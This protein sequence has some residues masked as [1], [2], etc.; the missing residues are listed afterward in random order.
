MAVEAW[1]CQS[2]KGGV[3]QVTT[4]TI[5]AYLISVSF[6]GATQEADLSEI[7]MRTLRFLG[8]LQWKG[9]KNCC[10][11]KLRWQDTNP[12]DL[13]HR[14]TEYEV[15]NVREMVCLFPTIFTKED[16]KELEA[17]ELYVLI[18]RRCIRAQ[19]L[20]P[21]SK[22]S[23]E[24]MW[25]ETARLKMNHEDF[26]L[27]QTQ[28]QQVTPSTQQVHLRSAAVVQD[29]SMIDDGMGRYS[30]PGYRKMITNIIDERLKLLKASEFFIR[31]YSRPYQDVDL[32][33]RVKEEELQ[34]VQ[35]LKAQLRIQRF[36][37]YN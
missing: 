8:L 5:R 10:P 11:A 18:L 19:L 27:V 29:V 35:N 14:V 13:G 21:M 25:N 24:L 9:K 12:V 36:S 15:E 20:V 31:S 16:D 6:P 17:S 26:V 2:N 34:D 32:V 23:D 4:T 7:E 28:L 3:V 37:G 1:T 22:H 33:K 30:A